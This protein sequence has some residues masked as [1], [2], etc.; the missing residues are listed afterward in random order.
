VLT[1]QLLQGGRG[2]RRRQRRRRLLLLLLLLQLSQLFEQLQLLLLLLGQ[3]AAVITQWQW[4][5]GGCRRGQSRRR[6]QLW[7]WNLSQQQVF[8]FRQRG[9][10][11]LRR[12]RGSRRGRYSGWWCDN[13][14]LV[15]RRFCGGWWWFVGWYFGRFGLFAL[16]FR[17]STLGLGFDTIVLVVVVVIVVF[18]YF[19]AFSIASLVHFWNRLFLVGTIVAAS[20]FA[21]SPFHGSLLLFVLLIVWFKF[22]RRLRF[23]VV[24]VVSVVVVVF[25]VVVMVRSG[26]C[27]A[28]AATATFAL[29]VVA[30]LRIFRFELLDARRERRNAL[31]QLIDRQLVALPRSRGIEAIVL[32]LGRHLGRRERQRRIGPQL[33]LDS[34]HIEWIR[35]VLVGTS[36]AMMMMR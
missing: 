25:V 11:R 10:R 16:L 36:N 9:T 5:C 19:G 24:V 32:A 20:S 6:Q 33:S 21:F 13:G 27:M 1:L 14:W 35:H 7:R 23:R 17:S 3:S 12:C 4:W 28:A 22:Y 2:G 30:Q 26:Y 34:A 15:S 29:T 8:Q 18:V 31:V